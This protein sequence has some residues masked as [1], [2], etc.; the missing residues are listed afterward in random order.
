MNYYRK[1]SRLALEWPLNLDGS[2]VTTKEQPCD[3]DACWGVQNVDDQRR[4]RRNTHGRDGLRRDF[5]VAIALWLRG[6]TPGTAMCTYFCFATRKL[7]A[8][9]RNSEKSKR[10]HHGRLAKRRTLHMQ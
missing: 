3:F 1:P 4:A 7:A 2:F 9:G 6:P 8:I 5:I 10:L